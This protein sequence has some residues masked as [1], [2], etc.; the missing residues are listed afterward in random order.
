MVRAAALAALSRGATLTA[1]SQETGISRAALRA[2]LIDPA[3]KRP[4][5]ACPVCADHAFLPRPSCVY[6][7]G[8]YL[9]DGCVSRLRR[10]MSLRITCADSWPQ[11][12]DECERAIVAVTGR[13]DGRVPCEGCTDLVNYWQHWPCLFPQHGPGRKHERM[14]KLAGWQADLVRTDPRPLVRGLQPSDGC[15]ITNTVHRPLPSGVRTYS[16]PRYLFTNHSADIL[17]I[18]TD[19]LDLLGISWRRNRWNSI[20]VARR[21]AV[22]ALDGFVGPK[23]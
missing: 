20:S 17:R 5:L 23:A 9:G 16:Y 3:P 13:P 1:V 14:I 21:D 8:M 12:M 18:Y 19:A 2:W 22:A 6:L 4:A 10:T 15:R 11:I 7:L